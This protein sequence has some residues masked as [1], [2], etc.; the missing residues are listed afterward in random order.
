MKRFLIIA[1]LVS[2]LLL[3]SANARE[4]SGTDVTNTGVASA[5]RQQSS[6]PT[7]PDAAGSPQPSSEANEGRIVVDV[8]S[9]A[10][11]EAENNSLSRDF[12]RA[13]L[14]TAF[15]M[16]STQR[17]LENCIKKRYPLGE[18]WIR[19]EMDS[20]DESLKLANLSATN[21]ADRQALQQLENEN[22]KLRAWTDW[23]IDANRNL[24]LADYY[25]SES[26][27]DNDEQFQ[28]NTACAGF[29]VSMLSSGKVKEGYGCR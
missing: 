10:P 11:D 4:N 19:S 17:A 9:H 22:G 5:S 28:S 25:M 7:T 24:R 21:D 29:L 14:S 20:I 27:L 13:A 12:A 3:A 1:S 26:K 15:R 8:W 2:G 23:L 18:Y 6:M 16:R